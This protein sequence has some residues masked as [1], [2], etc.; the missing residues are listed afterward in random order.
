M[1]ATRIDNSAIY[2]DVS[3]WP[4]TFI[5]GILNPIGPEFTGG[6]RIPN[7]GIFDANAHSFL[8]SYYSN[9]GQFSMAPVGVGIMSTRY[10]KQQVQEAFLIKESQGYGDVGPP[11]FSGSLVMSSDIKTSTSVIFNASILSEFYGHIAFSPDEHDNVVTQTQV[12]EISTLGANTKSILPSHTLTGLLASV[13]GR[14]LLLHPTTTTRSYSGLVWD[15]KPG[16]PYVEIA[17]GDY[18][19]NVDKVN[20]SVLTTPIVYLPDFGRVSGGI[21]YVYHIRFTG[22]VSGG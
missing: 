13:G 4:R 14:P 1:T 20:F 6:E 9:P 16:I 5:T 2:N 10:L 18:F 8:S 22:R 7:S 19:K 21:S 15:Q 12:S 3:V 11:N 17:F